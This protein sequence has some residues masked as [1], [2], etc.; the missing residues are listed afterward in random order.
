[1]LVAIRDSLSDLAS[2]NDGEDGEDDDDE[3][4]DQGKLSEDDKPRWVMST[5]IKTV[6]QRMESFQQEQMK[7]NELTQPGWEDSADYLR[8]RE[9]KHG[10]FEL[11]VPTVV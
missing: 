5:I 6:Q 1:M 2:S 10:T 11:R 9:K 8:E 3:E 7:L 4:T